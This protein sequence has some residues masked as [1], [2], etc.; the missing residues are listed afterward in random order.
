MYEA[1]QATAL[2]PRNG[3]IHVFLNRGLEPLTRVA[4]R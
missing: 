4:D 1:D 3:S 2:S